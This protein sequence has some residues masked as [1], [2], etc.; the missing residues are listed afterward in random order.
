MPDIGSNISHYRLVDILGRG[1]MGVVYRAEDTT[2]GR[3]VALKFLSADMLNNPGATERF[4]REARSAAA[5]NHSNI[6]TIY[7]IGEHEGQRFIAMELLEG[8]TLGRA[9]QQIDEV[10]NTAIQIA[11]ALNAAHAKGIIHRDIKPANIFIT[12][13]G[14]AKILDFGLAKLSSSQTESAATTEAFLTSPGAAVGTIAYMSPAQARG[15]DLDARSDLFSF[16]VVLYEMATGR[17][18]FTGNTSFA[19]IDAILHKAPTSALRI[20]PEL[21]NQL[22]QI[23]NK[24]LEKDLRLRYQSASDLRADLQRLKR[25]R[26]S[27]RKAAPVESESVGVKSLAVLPFANLSADKENEYFSDGLAEEITNALTRVPGLRVAARTSSFYFRGKESDVRKIGT[28]L[29]IPMLRLEEA[30]AAAQKAVKLDPLSPHFHWHLGHR[31]NVARQ[32]DSAIEQYTYAL[33]LDPQWHYAHSFLGLAYIQIERLDEGVR[34][35]EAGAHLTR[36]D[37]LSLS[38]LGL[39]YGLAGRRGHAQKILEELQEL[40]QREYVPAFAFVVN[41][42]GLR[43]ID[44][45]LEWLEISTDDHDSIMPT[46]RI[47]RMFDPLR[48]HSR[49]KA[50]LRKMNLEPEAT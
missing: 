43:E 36:Q 13:S 27:G 5:L 20:N 26:D 31:Y 4:L 25:D 7:E 42:A 41:Y 17:Q 40:A 37:P 11:D 34:S 1:G 21:P 28:K 14:Q 15:E 16:G 38:F 9:P 39:N 3:A 10:L 30:I 29:N 46:V 50:L 19:I 6:C 48:S 24:A 45:C 23:I 47:D 8:Q 32:Y 35:A 22:G 18:A 49:Y 33:E 2:L 12:R 44:K